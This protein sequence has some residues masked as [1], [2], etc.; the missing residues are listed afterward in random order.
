M[1]YTYDHIEVFIF[2]LLLIEETIA[3]DLDGKVSIYK[4]KLKK[5]IE[6]E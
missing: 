5:E 4:N 6:N 2:L 3:N 1:F